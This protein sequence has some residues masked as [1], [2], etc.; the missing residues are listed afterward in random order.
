MR[1]FFTVALALALSGVG[2]AA[3]FNLPPGKWWENERLATRIGLTEDQ[4]EEITDLVYD[5]ALEMVDLSAA[6]KRAELE[7]ANLVRQAEFDD[8]AVRAAFGGF[9]K[10]RQALERE[11]FE[12]LLAVR[13]VLTTE[14]WVQIQEIM[15]EM[16]RRRAQERGGQP[17]PGQRPPR[18]WRQGQPEGNDPHDSYY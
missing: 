11:R 1:I 17:Q 6:V 12:M 3:E 14:Q 16:R 15:Q 10:A 18:E 13:G 8:D 5:H 7:M 2:A 9:Q 4:K